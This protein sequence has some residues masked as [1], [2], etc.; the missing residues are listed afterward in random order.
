ME[1]IQKYLEVKPRIK[2]D[3]IED[4]IPCITT[5][6]ENS[7]FRPLLQ[8]ERL[9]EQI[10]VIDSLYDL[11]NY[12]ISVLVR[13]VSDRFHDISGINMNSLSYA[14]YHIIKNG[15]GEI[16]LGDKISYKDKVIY[17]RGDITIYK[18][19]LEKVEKLKRDR[20]FVMLCNEI[21][22]LTEALWEHFNKNITR[23]LI[24]ENESRNRRDNI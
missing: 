9:R 19:I 21:K 6:L 22:Y 8:I 2:L 7:E 24:N 11:I 13:E 18:K 15:E 23:V 20:E 12:H 16:I 14:I 5:C 3:V 10:E 17:E 4:E 1:L